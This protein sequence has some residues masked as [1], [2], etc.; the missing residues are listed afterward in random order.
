M[1]TEC[2]LCLGEPYILFEKDTN[3]VDSQLFE[4]F[5]CSD[6]FRVIKFIQKDDTNLIWP[7]QAIVRKELTELSLDP[8]EIDIS[9]SSEDILYKSTNGYYI[10]ASNDTVL[11]KVFDEAAFELQESFIKV[12]PMSVKEAISYLEVQN[13]EY[14]LSSKEIKDGLRV[15]TEYINE[16]DIC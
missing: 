7:N 4:L 12:K 9:F 15:Y 14:L 5:L 2:S 1:M 11:W 8:D 10:V 6:C 3:I 13:L 16:E